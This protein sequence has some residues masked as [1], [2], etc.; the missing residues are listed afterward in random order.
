LGVKVRQFATLNKHLFC[1]FSALITWDDM[2]NLPARK[3]A[4][5]KVPCIMGPIFEN[6][7]S[8]LNQ[9]NLIACMI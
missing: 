3:A 8:N 7:K 9:T 4:K 2:P 1:F 5:A 6:K